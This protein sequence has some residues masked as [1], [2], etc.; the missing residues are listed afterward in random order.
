MFYNAGVQGMSNMIKN[1]ANHPIKGSTAF[2]VFAL[3]G[4]LMPRLNQFL[5]NEDDDKTGKEP[6]NPYAE[7]PEYVRRNNLCIYSDKG[8]FITIALPIELRAM[9]GIGDMAASYINHPELRSTKNMG[10]DIVTQLSQIAPLDFFGEGAGPMWAIVPSGVRPFA[11]AAANKNWLG[12]PIERDEERWNQNKPRWTRA[13]KNVGDAY[14]GASKRLNAATNPYNDENIKGWADGAITDPALVEHIVNGYFGGVGSTVNR[15]AQLAK[16]ADEMSPNEAIT[17]NW[18]PIVRTQHYS[19]NERTRYART[20]NKWWYYKEEA[21]KTQ[22]TIKAL[23][24]RGEHDPISFMKS[25]S[26]EEGR[27]GD[28]AKVME[29]AYK[30][31][32]KIKKKMEKTDD[33]QQKDLYQLQ[34]DQ[35]MEGAVKE[36]DK[37]Q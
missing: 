21:D 23:K 2:A 22:E 9:Y 17:S 29:K 13:F 31:Y 26:E 15:V 16:H 20:R 1:V 3:A 30:R 18:M 28:R 36:L 8:N 32:S 34:M 24:A 33:L 25:V 35:I 7:L 27:K 19:P 12:Q 6:E 5:F 37:I 14:V 10:E 11:E 4:M